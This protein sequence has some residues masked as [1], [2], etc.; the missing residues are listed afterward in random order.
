VE[1]SSSK[2]FAANEAAVNVRSG[3]EGN[4]TCGLEIKVQQGSLNGIQVGTLF[5]G[6]FAFSTTTASF[7]EFYLDDI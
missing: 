4:A 7:H 3:L 6:R 1:S 5:V 2:V